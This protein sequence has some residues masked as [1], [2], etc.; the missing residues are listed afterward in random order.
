M[1][2]EDETALTRLFI[3]IP[4]GMEEQEV[5]DKFSEFGDIEY[6]QVVKDR[7]T[8]EKKGFG[9]VKYHRAYD[10]ARAL[11]DVDRI[12]KPVMAEPKA[13]KMK[14]D[15]SDA[16]GGGSQSGSMRGSY[17]DLGFGGGGSGSRGGGHEASNPPV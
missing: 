2:L 12:F 4:R 16:R 9:Y 5:R 13:S 1:D 8:G 11:E 17:M 7:N 14:R 6:V 15:I 3:L 10:A